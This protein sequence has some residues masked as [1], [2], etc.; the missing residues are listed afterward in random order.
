MNCSDFFTHLSSPFFPTASSSDFSSTVCFYLPALSSISTS[1][2]VDTHLPLGPYAWNIPVNWFIRPVSSPS[3]LDLSAT[4]T[5]VK[6]RGK[7]PQSLKAKFS[8][9]LRRAPPPSLLLNWNCL[10]PMLHHQNYRHNCPTSSLPPHLL[11]ALE[12]CNSS[13]TWLQ[14]LWSFLHQCVY[15]TKCNG[16]S[17]CYR[18]REHNH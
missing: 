4:L 18:N 3:S 2:V 14:T 6:P 8:R 1:V 13:E 11:M 12:V 9:Q 15:G 10:I 7:Q 5:S 16:T 17:K